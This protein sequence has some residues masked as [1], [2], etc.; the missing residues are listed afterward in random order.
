MTKKKYHCPAEMT[1]DVIG[2]KWKIIVLWLVRK[3]PK[4]SGK[5]KAKMPGISPAAFSAAVR[6]LEDAGLLK[7]IVHN[8]FPLEVSYGL[9]PK[10]ESLNPIV[11]SLVKWGLENRA[12]YAVGEFRMVERG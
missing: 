7:R 11:K 8:P 3:A 12:S 2:G 4:R 10:G 5:L 6:E 1:L 9:T